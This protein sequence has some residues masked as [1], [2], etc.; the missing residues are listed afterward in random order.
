MRP[1]VQHA[2]F[3]NARSRCVRVQ[4]NGLQRWYCAVQ[5]RCS[6]RTPRTDNGCRLLFYLILDVPG[7]SCLGTS[8]KPART[9]TLA[10]AGVV[11]ETDQTNPTR[12]AVATTCI[13]E[14]APNLKAAKQAQCESTGKKAAVISD[15]DSDT[16][17]QRDRP[18]KHR[19]CVK[20]RSGLFQSAASPAPPIQGPAPH[21]PHLRKHSRSQARSASCTQYAM[22]P[23]HNCINDAAQVTTSQEHRMHC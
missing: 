22:L 1:S 5:S 8:R 6:Q 10:D 7:A 4:L 21:P 23:E 17:K 12:T 3:A 13:A 9:K 20:L 16:T 2:R 19:A 15:R 11:V 18:D 14:H